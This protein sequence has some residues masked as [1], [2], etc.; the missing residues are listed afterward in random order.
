[1]F[2]TCGSFSDLQGSSRESCVLALSFEAL[3]QQKALAGL[4]HVNLEAQILW[5][6]QHFV[7]LE[8]RI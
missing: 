4:R 7:S 3:L 8:V 1:M 5:Q 6:A 2:W